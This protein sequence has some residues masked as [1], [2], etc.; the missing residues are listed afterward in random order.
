MKKLKH[1]FGWYRRPRII[2]IKKIP[3]LS[4]NNL[5]MH[6][7][8]TLRQRT[9]RKWKCKQFENECRISVNKWIAFNTEGL[10][11]GRADDN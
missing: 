10:K 5:R 11:D 7:L 4:N 2:Q 6:N 9:H 8:G 3:G 1:P